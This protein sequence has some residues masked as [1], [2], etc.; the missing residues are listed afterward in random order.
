MGR[1]G[2]YVRALQKRREKSEIDGYASLG[3][4]AR[5]PPVEL[6][7]GGADASKFLRGDSSWAVPPA[8]GLLSFVSPAS[9]SADQN[10]WSPGSGDVIRTTSSVD[11]AI[12]GLASGAAGVL[13]RIVNIGTKRITLRHQSS[14]SVAPNR[15]IGTGGADVVLFP[16][17]QAELLYDGVD[18]RWRCS[19]A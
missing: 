15:F 5:V 12:T 8:G 2:L 4:A 16:N 6:G 9:L 7:S 1:I 11:V 13:R 14:G 3:S 10:D 19:L 17:D 18:S